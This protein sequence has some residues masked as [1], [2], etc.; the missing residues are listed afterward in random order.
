[1]HTPEGKGRPGVTS[2]LPSANEALNYEVREKRI[3]PTAFGRLPFRGKQREITEGPTQARFKP[4]TFG[5]ST[6]AR[7]GGRDC[8]YVAPKLAGSITFGKKGPRARPQVC[9][10]RKKPT[11]LEWSPLTPESERDLG[12]VAPL[13]DVAELDVSIRVAAEAIDR[14]I[15]E[16]GE[17]EERTLFELSRQCSTPASRGGH[18]GWVYRS[19]SR[20]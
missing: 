10:E 13:I 20:A 16:E 3:E 18:V 11:T 2:G 15:R 9:D 6:F 19:R 17:W 1:M 4:I 14:L 12:Y 8:G 5:R 7:E